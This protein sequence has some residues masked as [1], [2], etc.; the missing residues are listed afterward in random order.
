LGCGKL[1]HLK[2]D[3]KNPSGNKKGLPLGLCPCY[4]KEKHWRNECKSKFHEDG[5]PLTK[6]AGEVSKTEN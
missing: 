1:G 3:C 4:G 5:P 2:K 6:E